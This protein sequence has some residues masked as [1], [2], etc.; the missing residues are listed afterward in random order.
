MLRYTTLVG[1]TVRHIRI[2]GLDITYYPSNDILM[3]CRAGWQQYTCVYASSPYA[4]SPY[5]EHLISNLYAFWKRAQRCEF[6]L[7]YFR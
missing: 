2:L 5:K 1:Y 4:S 7:H 6:P 3:A